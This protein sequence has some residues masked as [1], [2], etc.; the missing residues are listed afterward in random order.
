MIGSRQAKDDAHDDDD[1]LESDHTTRERQS[2]TVHDRT[3]LKHY[4]SFDTRELVCTEPA[5]VSGPGAQ[6][7]AE[8]WGVVEHPVVAAADPT[9]SAASLREAVTKI[10]VRLERL[11]WS[12]LLLQKYVYDHPATIGS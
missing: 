5:N 1:T 6:P 4:T 12:T 9:D 8:I 7:I 11:V 10:G 3:T 2:C